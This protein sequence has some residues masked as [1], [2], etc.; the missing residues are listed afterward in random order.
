M[1]VVVVPLPAR[2][3]ATCSERNRTITFLPSHTRARAPSFFSPVIS[4]REEDGGDTYLALYARADDVFSGKE[5]FLFVSKSNES[6]FCVLN[7][8]R[9]P[10]TRQRN[11][12]YEG[13]GETVC[14]AKTLVRDVRIWRIAMTGFFKNRTLSVLNCA[15]HEFN[16]GQI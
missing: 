12:D 7:T 8:R 13:Y 6:P 2:N 1:V 4:A 14:R 16:N 3:S 5:N 9:R 10:K 15:R 11:V